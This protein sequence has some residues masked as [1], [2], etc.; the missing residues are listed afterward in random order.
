M[1]TFYLLTNFWVG[2]YLECKKWTSPG[3]QP[4]RMTFHFFVFKIKSDPCYLLKWANIYIHKVLHWL[5]TK[6]YF[7]S[8]YIRGGFNCISTVL[9]QIWNLK[10][11]EWYLFS[12]DLLVK[13]H[14]HTRIRKA[15]ETNG[16]TR[17]QLRGMALPWD[18]F[19]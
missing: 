3:Q 12:F 8:F 6:K 4:S 16:Q 11:F 14:T 10:W 18:L 7:L 5:S 13:K 17:Y 9:W 2:F 1:W 15:H 19:L